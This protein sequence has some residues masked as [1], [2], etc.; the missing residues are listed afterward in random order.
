MIPTPKLL[1]NLL[2]LLRTLEFLAGVKCNVHT[3]DGGQ[4]QVDD[5]VWLAVQCVEL[6]ARCEV[7]CRHFDRNV[8]EF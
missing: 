5:R 7:I 8:Y 6:Q 3:N 1:W 2:T 4:I